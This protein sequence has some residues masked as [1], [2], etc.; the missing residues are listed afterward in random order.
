[1]ARENDSV[2]YMAKRGSYSCRSNAV[3]SQEGKM[4]QTPCPLIKFSQVIMSDTMFKKWLTLPKV[5]LL[6]LHANGRNNS[7]YCWPEKY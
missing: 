4:G 5:A 7:Q 3:K 2:L 6:K 1:M